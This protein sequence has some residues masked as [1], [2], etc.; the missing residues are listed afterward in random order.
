V[1]EDS[2]LVNEQKSAARKSERARERER[3]REREK[4]IFIY[5]V[6]RERTY[7]LTTL[8]IHSIF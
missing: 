6:R 1:S 4:I 5:P 7:P 2:T 8:T 3:E